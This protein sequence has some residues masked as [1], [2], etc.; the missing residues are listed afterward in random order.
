MFGG[1]D[2]GTLCDDWPKRDQIKA[3]VEHNIMGYPTSKYVCEMIIKQANDR[4]IPCKVFRFP[5][6]TGES[7]TGRLNYTNNHIIL[8]FLSY[9]KI[10]SIP[11]APLPAIVLPVDVCADLSLKLFWND[12]AP[13][14]VYNIAHPNPGLEVEFVQVAKEHFGVELE[15]VDWRSKEFVSKLYATDMPLA[16]L[17]EIYEDVDKGI[18]V[19][20]SGAFQAIQGYLN[21]PEIFFKNKKV[22]TY[23]PGFSANMFTSTMDIIKRNL[24]F[25]KSEG[26]FA[27]YGL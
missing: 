9:L 5:W 25:V 19:A 8:R 11:D 16:A 27:K 22:E 15:L 3:I 24:E 1:N 23:L 4:G 7:N 26:L 14:E 10:K 12:E 18:A 21:E 17:K 2:E 20:E 13:N 6:I